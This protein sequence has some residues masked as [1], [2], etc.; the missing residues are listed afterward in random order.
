[1]KISRSMRLII[2]LVA[3]AASFALL[4]AFRDS[5]TEIADSHPE[6]PET[7]V[8]MTAPPE[9]VEA[10]DQTDYCLECHQDKEALISTASQEEEVHSEN[11]GAG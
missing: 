9:L 4:M 11:E 7:T 10:G 8:E 2:Y 3:L 6:S 5:E 1:M